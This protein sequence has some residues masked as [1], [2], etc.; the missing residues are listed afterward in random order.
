[1][2]RRLADRRLYRRRTTAEHRIVSARVRPGH[3]VTVIDVSE[4]GALI[5]TSK[6]L[7][8]GS[9]VDLQFGTVQKQSA[10][11]GRVLR[12]QVAA[13]RADAVSYR[14]AIGFEYSIPAREHSRT[15][16][17]GVNASQDAV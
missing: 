12:C 5:E 1:M 13:L 14:A 16:S 8:P 15:H 4:G 10:V 9:V 7:L 3:A 2:I 11:R 6:G 17:N